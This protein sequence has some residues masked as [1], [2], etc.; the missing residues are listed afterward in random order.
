MPIEVT[1]R[2]DVKPGGISGAI[3]SVEQNGSVSLV[4]FPPTTGSS[5]PYKMVF[6]RADSPTSEFREIGTTTN[7]NRYTDITVNSSEQSYCYR[8]RYE[9]ACGTRSDSSEAICTIFL[10]KN[11]NTI[12]WTNDL[13]FTD[14]MGSYFVIKLNQGGASSE[15]GV[16]LN[17]TYDPKFDDP[18]E[19][20]FDYQIRARSRNGAFLSY[21]NTIV[22]RR[23]AALFLPD[24]FSPNGDGINDVFEARGVFFDDIQMIIYNRWGQS[25]FQS[26]TAGQ[27][28]DGTIAGERAPEGN[29]SYKVIIRD[30]TG[31]Q[32]VK[33]GTLLL[34][35]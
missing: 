21:S 29:Y 19:Q 34:L 31:T 24:A 25:I 28:W 4:A 18:T 26:S 3:V 7:L 9:N 10:Q 13:P 16:G 22:Y 30:T 5:S 20:Q 15:T 11:G 12:R 1:A 8:V 2:S 35:R 32:F 6:E 14:D 23:E 17:I 27:G 33:A